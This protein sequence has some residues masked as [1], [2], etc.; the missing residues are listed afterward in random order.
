MRTS[1][2]PRARLTPRA[3]RSKSQARINAAGKPTASAAMTAV[4]TQSG[5]CR[6][7]MSGSATWSAANAKIP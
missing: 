1:R 6:P 7:C 4:S 3:V 2:P 5:R